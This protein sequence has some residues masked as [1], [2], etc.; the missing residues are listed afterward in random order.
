[1]AGNAQGGGGTQPERSTIPLW[2]NTETDFTGSENPVPA[3]HID[4]L[5]KVQEVGTV[6]D[7]GRL[8]IYARQATKVYDHFELV[9][10]GGQGAAPLAATAADGNAA[11]GYRRVGYTAG[12]GSPEAGDTLRLTDTNGRLVAV[13]TGV[14]TSP[15]RFEY[16]LIGDLTDWSDAQVAWIIEDAQNFTISTA[17]SAFENINGA[18]AGGVTVTFADVG[19]DI[20]EDSTTERYAVTVNCNSQ[21]LADVYERLQWLTRRGSGDQ[22]ANWLPDAD[23][24]NEDGEFYRAIG[25][26]YA[27]LDAEAGA[28]VSEGDLVTGSLSSATGVVVAKFFSGG[29]GY[30]SLT[31]V[32]NGPFVNNDVIGTSGNTNTLTTVIESIVDL[33]PAPFGTFAGGTFFGARGVLLTNVPTADEN[34]YQLLDVTNTLKIPPASIIVQVTGG[35]AG[36]RIL[37]ALVTAGDAINKAQNGIGAAGAAVGDT[38]IPVD[39]QPPL[40]TPADETLRVVDVSAEDEYRFRVASWTGTTVTLVTGDSGTG[41]TGSTGNTLVDSA[42]NF[43]GTGSEVAIGD[44]IR[45]TNT[46]F[47]WGRVISIDSTTQLTTEPGAGESLSWGVGDGYE[48]NNVPVA[49]LD[50]DT[51]YFPY[52]DRLA[53]GSPEQISIKYVTDRNVVARLRWQGSNPILPFQSTGISIQSTGLN[54]AAVRT[55]DDISEN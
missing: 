13:V 38:T 18:V 41:T 45:R 44:I 33:K 17:V 2:S 34:N 9:L 25:D 52:M 24:G 47:G 28:G 6:I 40:D 50:A 51:C 20:D 26:T 36:D 1:M 12:T 8:A 54:V 46:P 11:D 21:P 16:Y 39:T 23:G 55:D 49:L 4:L 30:V 22:G 37:I 27:E 15:N 48:I 29:N 32:K 5:V 19:A 7:G 14:L 31:Q 10:T 53:A 42:A 3:G 35:I 43:G